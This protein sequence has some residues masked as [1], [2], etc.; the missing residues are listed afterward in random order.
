MNE[1]KSGNLRYKDIIFI[2][3]STDDL[4]FIWDNLYSLLLK[5]IMGENSVF[6]LCDFCCYK[7]SDFFIPAENLLI[8]NHLQ[9]D[10]WIPDRIR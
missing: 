6:L 3:K 8:Q 9:P 4:G 2:T 10:Q 1:I 5:N 7:E